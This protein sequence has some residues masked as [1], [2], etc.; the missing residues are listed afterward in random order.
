[1]GHARLVRGPGGGSLRSS[2]KRDA[3][4]EGRDAFHSVPD[5]ARVCGIAALLA[6]RRR[7]GRVLCFAACVLIPADCCCFL[8]ILRL[9][10]ALDTPPRLFSFGPCLPCLRCSSWSA[11]SSDLDVLRAVSAC[12]RRRYALR[13]SR[14]R[15]ADRPRCWTFCGVPAR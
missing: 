2:W 15:K 8:L 1:M 7:P 14:S 10:P 9:V 4:V 13:R 12:V 6:P 3:S 11:G 5:R